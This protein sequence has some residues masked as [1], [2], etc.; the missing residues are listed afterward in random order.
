MPGMR[1]LLWTAT[2]VYIK[3]YWDSAT[4]KWATSEAWQYDPPADY[5]Y[6]WSGD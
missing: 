2:S 5:E 1:L 6:K 3:M 4:H